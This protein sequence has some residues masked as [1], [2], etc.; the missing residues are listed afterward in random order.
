MKYIKEYDIITESTNNVTKVSQLKEAVKDTF[1]IAD[2]FAERE[3]A[4]SQETFDFISS[5]KLYLMLLLENEDGK[6]YQFGNTRINIK[7]TYKDSL[8]KYL[9]KNYINKETHFYRLS[10]S[11]CAL[12][13]VINSTDIKD[14]EMF[15]KILNETFSPLVFKRDWIKYNF[16]KDV[17]DGIARIR[18]GLSIQSPDDVFCEDDPFLIKLI[19][20]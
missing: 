10:N 17:N 5:D 2:K 6:T 12:D 16:W 18:I 11:D 8:F 7:Y 20:K 15:I 14:E 13:F 4:K 3:S 19:N 9:D 1:K